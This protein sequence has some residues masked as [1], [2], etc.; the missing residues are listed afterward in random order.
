MLVDSSSVLAVI[1][2][3]LSVYLGIFPIS[4][5]HCHPVYMDVAWRNLVSEP[6]PRKMGYVM[7]AM[8][9]VGVLVKT[10]TCT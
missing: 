3:L 8:G 5:R 1:N 9:Y 2:R 7:Q 4:C 6:D 10:N